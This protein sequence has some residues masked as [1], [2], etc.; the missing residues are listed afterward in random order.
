METVQETGD[1]NVITTET[2]DPGQT[3]MCSKPSRKRTTERGRPG[4]VV[5]HALWGV[6]V[7]SS[8][9]RL[10]IFIL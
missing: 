2:T 7:G 9:V 8:A 4:F 10:I 6:A 3:Y 1:H 5:T